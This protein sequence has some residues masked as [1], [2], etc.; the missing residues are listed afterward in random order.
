MGSFECYYCLGDA[1]AVARGLH[2]LLRSADLVQAA[3]WPQTVNVIGA[4][5][6]TRNHAVMDP[7]GHV[8][9]LYGAELGGTLVPLEVPRDVPL[10][11]V[12][13]IDKARGVLTVGLVNYSPREAVSLR[14]RLSHKAGASATVWR[15]QGAALGDMNIAGKPEMVT[16]ARLEG[17]WSPD[18][19]LVLPAHSITVVRLDW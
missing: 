4:I 18:Q 19:P 1:I 17:A 8:L 11:T 9:A 12:A 3:A 15:I 16:L 7:V 10:D 2:E 13:A 6:T 5:K 14:L